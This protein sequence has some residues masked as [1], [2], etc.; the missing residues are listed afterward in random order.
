MSRINCVVLLLLGL[1]GMPAPAQQGGD[2]EAQI[3]YAFHS[4]DTNELSALVQLLRTQEQSGGA[5]TALRYHLAHAQY[6]LGLLPGEQGARR[7]QAAFADCVDELKPVLEQQARA[8][9]ALVLQ[10]ACYANLARFDKIESVLLRSRAD[11]RL[12]GAFMLAP[13]NPRVLY[14]TAMAGL[15]RSKTGSQENQLA[16]GRLQLAAQL[17]EQ[18]SATSVD[19]PGWGHAEAYLDLGRQLELRGDVLGA[20][21]WIERSLI[22]APDF[23]AAQRQLASLIRH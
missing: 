18:T 9:E 3:L 2:L 8:A 13:R 7:A 15:A 17:F 10:A 22:V 6:R 4:E 12:T 23:K 20:R 16:F 1:A 11:D 19:V 5:D 21:N 14:L